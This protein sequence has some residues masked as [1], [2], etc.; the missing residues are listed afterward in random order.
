MLIFFSVNGFL[1]Q[2]FRASRCPSRCHTLKWPFGA[3]WVTHAGHRIATSME[4]YSQNEAT[5]GTCFNV[6]IFDTQD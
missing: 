6:H 5:K 3:H 4:N 1:V 2:S